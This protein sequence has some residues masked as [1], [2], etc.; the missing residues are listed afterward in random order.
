MGTPV[1][2]EDLHRNGRAGLL[3]RLAALV[4]QGA[5]ASGVQAADEV[6]ADVQR[7]A[8][9]E[10]RRHGALARVELRLDHRAGRLLGPGSP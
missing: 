5:H 6:V 1:E 8:L 3:D 10:H 4:E 9:H 2:A 7:P